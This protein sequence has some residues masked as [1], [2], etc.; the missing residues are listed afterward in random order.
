LGIGVEQRDAAAGLTP[1]DGQLRRQRR[2]ADAALL[3][4]DREHAGCHG[5]EQ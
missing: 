3:L 4:R 5:E 2:L 1:G